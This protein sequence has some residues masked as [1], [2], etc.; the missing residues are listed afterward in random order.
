MCSVGG[1]NEPRNSYSYTSKKT[2]K[3]TDPRVQVTNKR[4]AEHHR[5]LCSRNAQSDVLGDR[6]GYPQV[7][8]DSG[9][10]VVEHRLIMERKLGRPLVRGE[11]VRHINGKRTDNRPENLELLVGAAMFG[12]QVAPTPPSAGPND[13]LL[14]KFSQFLASEGLR[15]VK[16]SEPQ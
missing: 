6:S 11:S 9:T 4:C 14:A 16:A 2:S 8:D 3:K 13:I 7:R 10:A 15:V 1:C 12:Q 5:V